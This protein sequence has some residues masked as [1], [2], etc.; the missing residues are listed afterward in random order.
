[1][2]KVELR[3]H[4]GGNTWKSQDYREGLRV[5]PLN[6]ME[7]GILRFSL[8]S[9]GSGLCTE[10][11]HNFVRGIPAGPERGQLCLPARR[12]MR[13]PPISELLVP[14]LC[15]SGTAKPIGVPQTVVCPWACII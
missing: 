14:A 8:P 12:L 4:N 13:C 11:C 15:T 7:C 5:L 6:A 10:R 1:M 9:P 3:R 2:D